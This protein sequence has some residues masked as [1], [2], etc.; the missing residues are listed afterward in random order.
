MIIEI[1][2]DKDGLNDAEIDRVVQIFN[3]INYD[4][5]RSILE[6]DEHTHLHNEFTLKIKRRD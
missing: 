6:C 2:I 3:N 1:N 5:I 4:D